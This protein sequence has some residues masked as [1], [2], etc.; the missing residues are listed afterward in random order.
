MRQSRS[1]SE[2]MRTK[3]VVLRDTRLAMIWETAHS[4]RDTRQGDTNT[5]SV[6]LWLI[7]LTTTTA[8]ST[9]LSPKAGRTRHSSQLTSMCRVVRRPSCGPASVAIRR[10]RVT[11][12]SRP[13]RLQPLLTTTPTMQWGLL[14]SRAHPTGP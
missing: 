4:H 10:P 2:V 6:V 14:P 9:Y 5:M 13:F 7:R 11:C 3:S 12:W 1:I 8:C